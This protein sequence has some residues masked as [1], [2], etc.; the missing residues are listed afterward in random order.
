LTALRTFV[1]ATIASLALAPAAMAK[2]DGAQERMIAK[3]NEVRANHGLKALKPAPKLARSS[4]Y[5]AKRLMK[6]DGFGHGSSYRDAGFRTAG[7]ILAYG[8]GW[9]LKPS[10]IVRMWLASPGH[11]GLMLSSSF[12]YVGASPARGRF[13]RGLTTVWVVH[14]GAH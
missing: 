8:R 5:Y 9:S 4:R 13:G 6:V 7:E 14:F 2:V 10:P 3:I 11:R 12:D 1:L